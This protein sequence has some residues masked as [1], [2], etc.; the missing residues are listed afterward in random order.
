MSACIDTPE[1]IDRFRLLC[2][3]QSLQMFAKFKI[4]PTRSVNATSLLKLAG[5]A[6]GKAYKR[7]EHAKAALDVETLLNDSKA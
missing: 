3:K 5:A 4:L 1:Q 2:L 6:T 7:G